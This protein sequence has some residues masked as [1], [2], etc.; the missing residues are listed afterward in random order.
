MVALAAPICDL[1]LRGGHYTRAD[2]V[3][4]A[5]FLAIFSISL[6]LWSSQAIYIRAFYAAGQTLPPMLAGTII[7]IVSLPIYWG[8]HARFGAM[9]LAWASN[10]AILAHTIS[11]AVLLHVRK[12]MP[13]AR[14]DHRELSKSLAAAIASIIV[15][16]GLLRLT[17]TH[18][19]HLWNA[20]L[21]LVGTCIWAAVCWIV[22]K[23]TRSK[24]P[25]ELLRRARA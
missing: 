9:G 6:A 4:T 1:V 3:R 23:L 22:L 11:L 25:I 20:L 19:G 8:L 17:P 2:S 16:A 24:L 14:V 15:V 12:L 21:L 5:M 10:L 13:L 7:T 18:T